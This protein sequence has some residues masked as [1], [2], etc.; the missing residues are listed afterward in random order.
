MA[1]AC[2]ACGHNCLEA[3]RG[4]FV[5]EVPP[6]IP[7][8]PISVPDAEWAECSSCGETTLSYELFNALNAERS[9]RLGLLSAEEIKTI[10][11]NLGLTQ[12]QMAGL[13]GVGE[14][15]Y[16]RWESGKSVQN[17]SSDNLI[18][19][20]QQHP[21]LLV[22]LDAQRQPDRKSLISAYFMTL[23]SQDGA[24]AKAMA[25]LGGKVEGIDTD[26]LRKILRRRKPA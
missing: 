4:K 23:K 9:R 7:G 19:M 2:P 21:D 15:T 6:D 11:K 26:G 12:S 5:F 16:T 13:L 8:G 25:A 1:T 22:S 17:K 20:A 24:N 3:K 14:K 10:R 18:R